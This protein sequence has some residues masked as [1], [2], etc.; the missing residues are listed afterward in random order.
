VRSVCVAVFVTEEAAEDTAL[1]AVFA[2]WVAL[3]SVCVAVF[4]TEDAASF[5]VSTA[6]GA[7]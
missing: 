1:V 6:C 7:P 3:L 5:A 2:S 4:V